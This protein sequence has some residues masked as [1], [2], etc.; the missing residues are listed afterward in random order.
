MYFQVAKVV[1]GSGEAVDDSTR[2]Y[3]LTAAATTNATLVK[4]GK[5]VMT[6]ITV[7]NV[8]AALRYLRFYDSNIAPTAGQGTPNRKF[9]IPA[10]TTGAGFVICPMLPMRFEVGLAFT[11]TT[12]V[13]DTD[14]TALTANDV[15]LT[16]E[17]I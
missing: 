3:T 16:I 9:A 12:G 7:V 6:S 1:A 17:Y 5:G 8:A 2:P 4:A 14:A 13:A 15:I 11:L 10:S